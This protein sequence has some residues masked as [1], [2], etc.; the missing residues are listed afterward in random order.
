MRQEQGNEKRLEARKTTVGSDVGSNGG[1]QILKTDQ[2]E[3]V[4]AVD[5]VNIEI[6]NLNYFFDDRPILTNVNVTFPQGKMYAFVGPPHQGKST[7]LRIM[8]QVLLP[9]EGSSSMIFF[10]PHLRVLHLSQE[11]FFLSHTLLKNIVFHT[12]MKKIGGLER[13]R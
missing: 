7:L 5:M 13:I 8:G 10:P 2:G 6:H 9:D 12:D 3:E 11:T 1:P 4:F